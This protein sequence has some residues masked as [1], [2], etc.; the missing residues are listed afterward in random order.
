VKKDTELEKIKKDI[1]NNNIDLMPY[2]D[3]YWG[4]CSKKKS[5]YINAEPNNK[6]G[7]K[8]CKNKDDNGININDYDG[9]IT[10]EIFE[11]ISGNV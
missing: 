9:E 3:S 11:V 8:S 6:L 4:S 7:I 10:E 5:Y 1:K 2:S